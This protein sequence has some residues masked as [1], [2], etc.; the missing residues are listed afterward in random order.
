MRQKSTSFGRRESPGGG[1]NGQVAVSGMRIVAVSVILR[2]LLPKIRPIGSRPRRHAR[3]L[4]Y[5]RSPVVG[6]LCLL[7]VLQP[8]RITIVIVVA[9]AVHI[10]STVYNPYTVPVRSRMETRLFERI[11]NEWSIDDNQ[12]RLAF[13]PNGNSSPSDSDPITVSIKDIG[14]KI[15]VGSYDEFYPVPGHRSCANYCV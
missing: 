8:S 13:S 11:A 1:A 15:R 5:H 14:S 6:D 10:A 7:P 4:H 2:Q 9:L 3:K 12:F